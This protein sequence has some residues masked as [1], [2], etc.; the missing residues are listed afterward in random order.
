MNRPKPPAKIFDAID[1]QFIPAMEVIDWAMATF[2]DESAELE[3]PEHAHL[4][5]ASIAALWTN[6]SNGKNGRVILAQCELRDPMAM[7]KWAKAKARLQLIEWFGRVPDFLIT[8]DAGYASQCSDIEW[9][10]LV[11]HELLHAA[12]AKDPFGAPRFSQSTG[13]P[14]FTIRGHDVEEFTSIVRRY[15]DMPT[16]PKLSEEVKTFIVQSLACF[17]TPSTVAAAVKREFGVDVS[18]QSV[19]SHDPNKAASKTLAERWRQLFEVTRKTFLEDTSQIAISHRAVRLRAL[20][21]MAEKAEGQGNMVLAASLMEQA[22]KE[23]GD[24]YTNKHKVEHSGGLSLNVTQEDA[25]L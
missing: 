17:D 20:Q 11:E 5:Y 25:E 1:D 21:R 3:N 4:R 14:V 12:Q 2:I 22:A 13:R 8:F 10:A 18:R 7:G 19:E 15:T 16:K 9:C 24:A 23:C 6:V